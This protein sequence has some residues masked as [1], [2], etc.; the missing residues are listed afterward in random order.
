MMNNKNLK[1]SD[2]T[3]L[4]QPVERIVI[5]G[6]LSADIDKKPIREF[7]ARH[8]FDTD[9]QVILIRWTVGGDAYEVTIANHDAKLGIHTEYLTLCETKH[10]ETAKV[11]A[12]EAVKALQEVAH[13]IFTEPVVFDIPRD[14]N[15]LEKPIN[16]L[17]KELEFVRLFANGKD[18]RSRFITCTEAG[19]VYADIYEENERYVHSEYWGMLHVSEVLQ[20]CEGRF[21]GAV[22][23]EVGAGE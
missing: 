10:L 19:H 6:G 9:M 21:T 22:Y 1:N 23:K 15:V 8:N 16:K 17:V 3:Y 20:H 2:Y 5:N 13:T 4:T 11:I 14:S 18:G 12:R 7:A